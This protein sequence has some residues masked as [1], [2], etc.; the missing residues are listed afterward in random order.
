LGTVAVEEADSLF[1][2][3]EL[4]PG[5]ELCETDACKLDQG[6]DLLTEED[7]ALRRLENIQKLYRIYKVCILFRLWPRR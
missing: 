5:V 4:Q 2:D 7:L 6:L 3:A 1:D